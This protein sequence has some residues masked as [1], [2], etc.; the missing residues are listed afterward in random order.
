MRR[1]LA[2]LFIPILALSMMPAAVAASP[3]DEARAQHEAVVAFWTPERM[4]AAI[5]R[6]IKFDSVR[7]YHPAAKPGTGGGGTTT[8][9]TASVTGASW[10][11]GGDVLKGVGKVFFQLG[12]FLYQ[13]SATVVNDTRTNQSLALTAAHCAFDKGKFATNWMFIP[14]YDSDPV[15]YRDACSASTH[16]CWTAQALFVHKSFADQKRFNNTAVTHDFAF[17]LLGL[18]GKTPTKLLE[19]AVNGKFGIEFSGPTVGTVLSAYGYPAGAPY[20]GKDLSYCKGPI[21]TDPN[22]G[23]ATWSMACNMTGG[24]S[25]GGW[26]DG[27]WTSYTGAKLRSLNSYGYSGVANM[28]GPKLNLRAQAVYNAANDVNRTTNTIVTG[29]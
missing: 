12:A 3:A 1:R 14:E 4:K 11:G 15:A 20:D 28:Y 6:E 29:G 8:T 9:S 24:S 2:A 5:P 7:G 10:G 18:G 22:T 23:N 19:T 27:D 17:A 16:G 26:L 21:G 13:C 25:G